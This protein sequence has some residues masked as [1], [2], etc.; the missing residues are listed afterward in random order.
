M[1]PYK[2]PIAI[3][4]TSVALVQPPLVIAQDLAAVNNIA[5]NISVKITGHS[6]GSGFIL[7]RE[8]NVY[9]VVTNKHVVPVDTEYQIQT[10]DGKQHQV[11][12][13]QEIPDLDL[14]II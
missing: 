13:R 7:E 1:F 5:R 9:S 4:I 14:A 10:Y 2:V 11:T 8:G 12:N 3:A 6:N